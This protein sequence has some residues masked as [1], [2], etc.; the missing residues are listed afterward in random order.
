MTQ[1]TE[2]TLKKQRST[3]DAEISAPNPPV[4]GASWLTYNQEIF[5][6]GCHWR[7]AFRTNGSMILTRSLPVF[8]TEASTVSLSHGIRVLRSINSQDIPSYKLHYL[9]HNAHNFILFNFNTQV[10]RTAFNYRGL[11]TS[12][13]STEVFNYGSTAYLT[14][15]GSK[16]HFSMEKK[17]FQL[18]CW[19]AA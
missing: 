8:R 15:Y 19:P 16:G 6:W 12:V 5:L 9:N 3:I 17:P 2:L 18:P 4:I 13:R 10:K 7:I 11:W 14:I 1:K